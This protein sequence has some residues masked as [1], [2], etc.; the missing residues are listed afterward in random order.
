VLGESRQT[1]RV[2]IKQTVVA[3][4]RVPLT[5]TVLVL[6]AA[7]EIGYALLA[8][9]DAERLA[10]WASTNVARLRTEPVGPM[11][12]SAFVVEDNPIA[13]LVVATAA[14]AVVEWRLGW[15]RALATAVAA[16]V[17]GTL[18]S[19]GIVWWRVHDHELPAGA[20]YQ[21]DV[22]VSYVV[23]GILALAAVVAPRAGQ[24]VAALLLAALAPALLHGISTLAVPAVGHLTA[25]A[26]GLTSGG[27]LRRNAR[28]VGQWPGERAT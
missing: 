1:G 28:M 14:F 25:A 2:A 9:P 23:V 12:V 5:V 15:W 17:V 20:L 16:H 27:L 21:L 22:G 19:E 13:W 11:I 18:V 7:A 6:L 8:R 26:V 24:V 3:A 4:R 10:A